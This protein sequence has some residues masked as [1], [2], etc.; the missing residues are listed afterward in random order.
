MRQPTTR[1][2]CVRTWPLADRLLLFAYDLCQTFDIELLEGEE[3]S[4]L[5]A[6][7]TNVDATVLA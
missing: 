7:E 4:F 2:M 1:S 6:L 3:M 5:F